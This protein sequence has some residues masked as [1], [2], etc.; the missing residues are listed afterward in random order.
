MAHHLDPPR[1]DRGCVRLSGRFQAGHAP[2]MA[3]PCHPRVN[4][5]AAGLPRGRLFHGLHGRFAEETAVDQHRL[6]RAGL[7]GDGRQRRPQFLLVVGRRADALTHDQPT[8]H[9]HGRRRVVALLEVLAVAR[10]PDPALRIGEVVLLP[11]LGSGA[12]SLRR[13]AANPFPTF[14]SSRSLGQLRR[15]LG[16]W[17]GIAGGG[18]GQRRLALLPAGDLLGN[19]QALLER[20]RIGLLG[21]GQQLLHLQFQL[22]D[23]LPG[24]LV[25]DRAVLAGIGQHLGAVD[26]HGKL[27]DWEPF[28]FPGQLEDL[29]EARGQEVLVFAAEGAK[30]VVIGVGVGGEEAHRNTVVSALPDAAAAEGAGGV[31]V[32][33]QAQQHAGRVWG[34]AGA[35]GVALDLAQ[36]KGLDGVEDEMD[37]RIGGYPLAQIGGQ[38]QRGVAVNRDATNSPVS[39]NVATLKAVHKSFQRIRF[40][41]SDRL[42]EQRSVILGEAEPLA[43]GFPYSR[44]VVRLTNVRTE[45]KRG[46]TTTEARYYLS[47]QPPDA[48]T[49]EAWINL[50]R[51]HWA[52]VE[53]RNHWRRDATLGEE[54]LRFKHPLA[55]AN[56]ALLRSVHLQLLNADREPEWLPVKRE[57]LAAHPASALDL[58][59][60][61]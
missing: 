56:L 21:F 58:L 4:R 53:N 20:G 40:S 15:V 37:Q 22:L 48:R 10:L 44:T 52:G 2:V 31:A 25:T 34:A 42:L 6:Q 46:K 38:E 51:A 17:G 5:R 47:S 33:E 32:D 54:G 16:Q 57:R 27:A 1:P 39:F 19:R 28:E 61:K 35:A 45:T 18:P 26:R 23:H 49:P 12:G 29:H 9:L 3:P 60:I 55:T 13:L 41:K 24:P 36:V 7:R 14:L 43:T 50:V 11:G 8:V 30:G 59:R